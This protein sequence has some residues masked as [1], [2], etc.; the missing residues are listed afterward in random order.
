MERRVKRESREELGTREET[1]ANKVPGAA[2][3]GGG[4]EG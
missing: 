3:A 4:G 1:V 2:N